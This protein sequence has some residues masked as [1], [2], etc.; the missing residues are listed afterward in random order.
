MYEV[1]YWGNIPLHWILMALCCAVSLGVA[2]LLRKKQGF[3]AGQVCLYGVI[4]GSGY[5][6]F[7]FLCAI[8]SAIVVRVSLVW[9]F[10][11][12][13][14]LGFTGIALAYVLAPVASG[15]A[16]LIFVLSGKWKKSKILKEEQHPVE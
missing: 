12:F 3:T 13:T 8:I 7:L 10:D 1:I 15:L 9:A 16:A 6:L 4:A 14:E 5:T 2:L 11:R